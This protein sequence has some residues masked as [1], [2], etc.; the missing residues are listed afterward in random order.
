MHFSS[1]LRVSK[2]FRKC[3]NIH[4]SHRVPGNL[5]MENNKVRTVYP[6]KDQLMFPHKCRYCSRESLDVR[7][8][9]RLAY[10]QRPSAALPGAF[11]HRGSA[12]LRW[13]SPTHAQVCVP[14]GGHLCLE[15]N[16]HDLLAWNIS[17]R[18][19]LGRNLPFHLAKGN[20]A[21]VFRSFWNTP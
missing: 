21:H 10:R 6:L 5:V 13:L 17:N 11:P 15:A 9:T 2:V 3:I 12:D 18:S 20:H 19:R 14:F 4:C 8:P 7:I 1:L 16:S